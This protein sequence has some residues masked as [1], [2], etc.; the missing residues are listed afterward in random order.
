MKILNDNQIIFDGLYTAVSI[1]ENDTKNVYRKVIEAQRHAFKNVGADPLDNEEILDLLEDAMY[2]FYTAALALEELWSIHE[3]LQVADQELPELYDRDITNNF[4]KIEF[5][6]TAL[7]EQALNSWRSF[8]DF[9]LKYLIRL[10]TGKYIVSMSINDYKSEMKDYLKNNPEDRKAEIIDKYIRN[11]V[12]C[13]TLHGE[14][15]SW[16]DILKSLRDKITHQKALRPTL[17]ERK[18]SHGIEIKWP[19]VKDKDYPELIQDF[20]NG[21]FDMIK[22]FFPEIYGLDWIAGPYKI[23]MFD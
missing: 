16:G 20:E 3:F 15:E 14:T 17:V 12:L 5:L 22:T 8:L 11:K 7:L 4:T 2:K 23:G 21:A 6:L 18:N 1:T 13:Q 9:F 10:L 19:T